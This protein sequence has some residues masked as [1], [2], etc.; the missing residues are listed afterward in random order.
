MCKHIEHR[1]ERARR[2]KEAIEDLEA[3]GQ[4]VTSLKDLA[5]KAGY[6]DS[7]SIALAALRD[8]HIQHR[9]GGRGKPITFIM[10][11]D[12]QF[13]NEPQPSITEL[14]LVPEVR[15]GWAPS[16]VDKLEAVEKEALAAGH[17]TNTWSKEEALAFY[18]SRRA[19]S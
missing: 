10:P 8:L 16:L 2:F 7:S 1:E 14:R 9:N 12:A 5:V 3:S 13:Y 6:S 18:K 17:D 19:V 4:Y 15:I 11:G